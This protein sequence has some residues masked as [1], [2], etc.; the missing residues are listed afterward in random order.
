MSPRQQGLLYTKH[1][2]IKKMLWTFINEYKD[3]TYISQINAPRLYPAIE[4][5]VKEEVPNILIRAKST[6]DAV[7]TNLVPDELCC[8]EIQD[9]KSVYSLTFFDTNSK[10][11]KSKDMHI[12]V[13]RTVDL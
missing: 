4:R 7:D 2:V 11:K 13:I 8:V 1:G 6:P 12:H 5:Y 10:I 9:I 3:G